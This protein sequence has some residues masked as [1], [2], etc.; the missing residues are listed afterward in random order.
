MTAE[1]VK[2]TCV[3]S[4]IH[5]YRF[6]RAEIKRPAD[7]VANVRYILIMLKILLL[8]FTL[9]SFLISMFILM[10][11]TDRHGNK[12][13]KARFDAR[14]KTKRLTKATANRLDKEER[15]FFRETIASALLTLGGFILSWW[16]KFYGASS[17]R[18]Y[19]LS[20]TCLMAVR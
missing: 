7:R 1:G 3:F 19:S 16:A 8:F 18:N 17:N 10:R 11:K 20:W 5:E 9:R 4:Q 6:D 2:F 13:L 12:L 14:G 15:A